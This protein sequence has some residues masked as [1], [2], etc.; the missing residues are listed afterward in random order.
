M[1]RHFTVRLGR[2]LADTLARALAKNIPSHHHRH[3]CE[4]C[5]SQGYRKRGTG[6]IIYQ[7][8][9]HLMNLR[10]DEKFLEYRD[11]ALRVRNGCVNTR[12]LIPE[13]YCFIFCKF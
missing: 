4:M 11:H 13:E 3:F 6:M 10:T 2:L 9:E 7:C 1:Q 12:I 5:T 8:K